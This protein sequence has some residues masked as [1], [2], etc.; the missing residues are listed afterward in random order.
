MRFRRMSCECNFKTPTVGKMEEVSVSVGLDGGGGEKD[1]VKTCLYLKRGEKSP[2]EEGLKAKEQ[3]S[4]SSDIIQSGKGTH[5]SS[6]V[7]G[8]TR[9]D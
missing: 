2:S 3:R 1:R 7:S 9:C 5:C 6:V 4:I 8:I